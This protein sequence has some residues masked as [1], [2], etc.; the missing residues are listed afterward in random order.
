[1]ADASNKIKSVE[2]T[3]TTADKRYARWKDEI[4]YAEKELDKFHITGRK[5]VKRFVDKRDAV[6]END[7]KFNIFTANVGIMKASLYANI[8]KIKVGRRFGQANDEVARMASYM[9]QNAVM[10]DI[11]EPE[12]DFDQVMRDAVEDRL[13]PGMGCAWLRIDTEIEEKTLEE[14]WDPITNEKLQEAATYETVKRQSVEID[15]VNWEDFLYSPCRTWKERRW[16]GRRV[17]MDQDALVKRFA[18]DGKMTPEEVRSIP[19]DYNPKTNIEQSNSPQHEALQKAIVYEIWD[20][21]TRKVLW[22]CKS[23]PK[24]LDEADDPLQLEDFEPCPKPLFAT[25]TTSNCVATSDFYLVQDQ[26]NELDLVNNRIS[27]LVEAMKVVGVYDQSATGVQNM[28]K[29]SE[30]K[31]IP[32][33]NWAMFAEKGGIKGAIDWMPLEAIIAALERLRQARDDIK[34]QIYELTGISDI[35]R[36][37]TKASETLGAQNLK[38]QFAN[39]RIQNLQ[40]DVAKFAQ[41][42]LRIKAELICRHFVPEQIIKLSNIEFHAEAGNQQL[43]QAAI[44]LLKGDHELFEWR[45]NVQADSLALADQATDKADKVEFTNAVAT[46][47]QSAATTLKAMPDTAPIIFET[48]KYSISGFRGAQEL[49]GVID[50]T[51]KVIMQKIQNPPPPPPDPAVVKTQLE[52]KLAAEKAQLDAQAKK[53]DMALKQQ[54][55]QLKAAG[56]VQDLKLAQQEHQM[57]LANDQ[58]AHDQAVAQADTKFMQTVAQDSAKAQQQ[59]VI[60]AQKAKENKG[61]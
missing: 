27:L 38:A 33:D 47:L 8:P 5:V 20:R 61:E 42:I 55:F 25:T 34:G 23:F 2:E 18:A 11:D 31:L 26:Y 45:V 30:N 22:L 43:I 14:Q 29:G 53:Q 50:N 9:L 48:L 7:R 59:M 24:M 28:L 17:Y 37:N 51:L 46:F 21:Q 54:D 40:T 49:E 3:N 13:V 58:Q 52:M 36:G 56:K 41:G 60:A 1:M 15:H 35:V 44:A 6:D 4:A 32:V 57:A 16:V 19:L 10:Q 12:C 39:V